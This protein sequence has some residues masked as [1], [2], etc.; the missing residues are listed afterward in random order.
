MSAQAAPKKDITPQSEEPESWD[1]DGSS[2][3]DAESS[4]SDDTE[5]AQDSD[6]DS[7]VDPEAETDEDKVL[8][9]YKKLLSTR[10]DLVGDYAGTELFLIEGDSL[11]LRCFDD[12]SLDFNPGLQLLHAR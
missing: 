7:D 1:A 5:T 11:L 4:V 3:S 10:V 2:E 6:A 12:A 8:R 9:S